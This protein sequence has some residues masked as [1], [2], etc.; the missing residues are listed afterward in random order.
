MLDNLMCLFQPLGVFHAIPDAVE[1]YVA[2]STGAEKFPS[3]AVAMSGRSC[4]PCLCGG[5]GCL[6]GAKGPLVDNRGESPH[7]PTNHSLTHS[8]TQKKNNQPPDRPTDR[9]TA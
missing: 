2:L 4:G 8:L 9:S 5:M 3:G 1:R 6:W 7:Q